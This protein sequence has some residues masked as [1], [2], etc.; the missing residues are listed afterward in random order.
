M[1]QTDCIFPFGT[2]VTLVEQQDRTPKPVFV[3]GVY[4]SAVHARWVGPDG[5]QKIAAMAVASEP[6]IFWRGDGAE[7]TIERIPVPPEAGSLVP[8]PANLNGPS[9]R[10]LNELFLEPMGVTRD[11]TW[12]CDIVPHACWNAGQRKAVEREYMPLVE[13]LGLPPPA[14]P[15]APKSPPSDDRIEEILSE[16]RQS[17]AETVVLLGDLPI[18]WFTRRLG[19]SQPDL[20]AFGRRPTPTGASTPSASVATIA[21][22]CPCAIPGRRRGLGRIRRGG[23]TC[24]AGGYKLERDSDAQSPAAGLLHEP[25]TADCLLIA[26]ATNPFRP[27]LVGPRVGARARR[28][29]D[30]PLAAWPGEGH[31]LTEDGCS[32]VGEAPKVLIHQ[33]SEGADLSRQPL[34]FPARLELDNQG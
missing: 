1:K 15:D 3:L 10:A 23:M 22:S 9:G 26:K 34:H 14:M 21:R 2:P 27:Q 25:E 16:L 33:I 13:K 4:A 24:T 17:E 18:K 28:W 32:Y 7:G 29:P 11:E 30:D 19:V 6:E 31:R 12:L 20:A 5:R 8:A